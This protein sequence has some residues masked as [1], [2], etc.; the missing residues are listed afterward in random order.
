MRFHAFWP[1]IF[2]FW[3]VLRQCCVCGVRL[4]CF[5]V[6]FLCFFLLVFF[7]IISQFENRGTPFEFLCRLC[8]LFYIFWLRFYCSTRLYQKKT[9]AHFANI[10]GIVLS[11]YYIYIAL[12]MSFIFLALE[13]RATVAHPIVFKK[14][15]H[16]S[17]KIMGS[18]IINYGKSG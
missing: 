18:S 1:F 6:R 2:A 9:C 16:K 14:I 15:F 7:E 10:S 13:Y 11:F 5:W 12:C 4:V 17:Q 8:A 3:C